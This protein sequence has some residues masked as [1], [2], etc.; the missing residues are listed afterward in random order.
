MS[1]IKGIL[2]ERGLLLDKAFEKI[3]YKTLTNGNRYI[4]L[5]CPIPLNIQQKIGSNDDKMFVWFMASA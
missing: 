3:H 2:A 1:R 4:Y 5:A